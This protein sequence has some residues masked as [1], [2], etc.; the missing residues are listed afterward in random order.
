MQPSVLLLDEPTAGLDQDTK[1]R[2]IDTLAN[3]D[4]TY[5]LISHEFDFLTATT[6][7]MYTIEDGKIL[8]D[9]ELHVHVH[10]HSHRMGAHPHRHV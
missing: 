10:E 6:D 1:R 2:L 4:M 5:M 3:L 7:H 8:V 9:E